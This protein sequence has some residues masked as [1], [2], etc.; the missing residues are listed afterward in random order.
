M[1]SSLVLL[2]HSQGTTTI[3]SR[4]VLHSV[5]ENAINLEILPQPFKAERI[6]MGMKVSGTLAHHQGA[7]ERYLEINIRSLPALTFSTISYLSQ[8]LL[9]TLAANQ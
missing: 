5:T 4:T 7:Y 2:Q 3:A 8:P 9:T 1:T 6:T